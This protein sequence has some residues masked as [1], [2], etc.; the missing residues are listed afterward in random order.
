MYISKFELALCFIN[1]VLFGVFMRVAYDIGSIVPL[2]LGVGF[3]LIAELAIY[4]LYA[5]AKY[6]T[7]LQKRRRDFATKEYVSD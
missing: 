4:G 2:V 1:T 5:F 7:Y 3:T 6:I